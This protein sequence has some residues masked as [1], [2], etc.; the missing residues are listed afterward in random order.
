MKPS[1][2]PTGKSNEPPGHCLVGIAGKM[3]WGAEDV[4]EQGGGAPPAS[5]VQETPRL[6]N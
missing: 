1:R 3:K 4:L 5:W 2:Y 6:A